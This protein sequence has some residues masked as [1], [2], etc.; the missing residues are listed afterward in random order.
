[1][2]MKLTNNAAAVAATIATLI[3]D[4]AIIATSV[5]LSLHTNNFHWM[6][7]IGLIFCT[8]GYYFGNKDNNK[9]E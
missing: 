5:F 3:A 8:G 6:W 9:E 2:N 7:L 1:M 4:L